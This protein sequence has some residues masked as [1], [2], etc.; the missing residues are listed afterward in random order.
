MVV[1]FVENRIGNDLVVGNE[2]EYASVP[3]KVV[4]Y[5]GQVFC[6]LE[7]ARVFYYKYAS[8]SGFDARRSS[9]RKYFDKITQKKEILEKVFCCQMQG[10]YVPNDDLPEPSDVPI[11]VIEKDSV[12]DK[13]ICLMSTPKSKRKVGIIRRGCKAEIRI[14]KNIIDNAWFVLSFKEEHNHALTS[15]SK[16]HYLKVNRKISD[17]MRRFYKSLA[18]VGIK[19]SSQVELAA[20]QSGGFDKMDCTI[21]DVVNMRRDIRE[22]IKDYDVDLLVDHF[23]SRKSK[24]SNFFYAYRQDHEKRLTHCFWADA[25]SIQ[26]C[27][28]FGD[29]ITFD[30]TY[31]TNQYM[32]IYGAFCGVNHHMQTVFFASVFMINETQESF[33]WVFSKFKECFCKSPSVLITDQDPAMNAAIR[34]SFKD[35]IHHFCC[36]HIMSKLPVKLGAVAEKKDVMNE[37]HKIV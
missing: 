23:E 25:N 18:A 32:M 3:S 27:T 9:S 37:F 35:T 15:P 13:T 2:V 28:L 12:I 36:W 17:G 33:E 20:L 26:D 6:T 11:E 1:D 29:A 22:E 14:K 19:P 7:E 30:T 24:N 10:H 4:P 31:K 5:V 34:E 8:V 16:L 21:R